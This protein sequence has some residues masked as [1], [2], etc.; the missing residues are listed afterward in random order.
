[1]ARKIYD[2]SWDQWPQPPNYGGGDLY[3]GT[4]IAQERPI[5]VGET[6]P[7]PPAPPPIGGGTGGPGPSAPSMGG[8]SYNSP[9][10]SFPTYAAPN[11]PSIDPLV[12][13]PG[14]SYPDYA[15]PSPFAYDAFAAPSLE[16]A[17]NEPGYAFARDEGIRAFL[18]SRL[19]VLR[20]GGTVKDLIGWGNRFAEQNYGNVY[21]RAAN[22][23][24]MNRGNAFDSWSANERAR[25]DTYDRNRSNAAN[26]YQMNWGVTTDTYDRNTG[27]ALDLW[28]RAYQ[29]SLSQFNPQFDAAKLRFQD[30]YN[31][32]RDRLNSL[33]NI[34]TAGAGY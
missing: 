12:A 23:Y 5:P 15:A 34:A 18:N 3:Y 16:Q 28:D 22:T 33:T 4:P 14:F 27:T 25:A 10:F 2:D 17:Q 7:P 30:I 26:A 21:N 20:T 31:R 11:P 13:P 6:T 9:D 32:D 19:P 24:T 29:A 8:F 1:M